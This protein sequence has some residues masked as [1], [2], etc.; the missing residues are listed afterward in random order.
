MFWGTTPDRLLL[1]KD[2][3]FRTACLAFDDGGSVC[4]QQWG[5]MG[6]WLEFPKSLRSLGAHNAPKICMGARRQKGSARIR[7]CAAAEDFFFVSE[8]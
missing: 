2:K 8:T 7:L 6:Q 4:W 1:R 3:L 5:V